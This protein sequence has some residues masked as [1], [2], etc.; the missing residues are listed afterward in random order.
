MLDKNDV[1]TID[2]IDD[3]LFYYGVYAGKGDTFIQACREDFYVASKELVGKNYY[4]TKLQCNR[5]TFL[6]L[7][8]DR[9]LYLCDNYPKIHER[10]FYGLPF[11]P[12][13]HIEDDTI[14]LSVPDKQI[15]IKYK[16]TR[17]YL[18]G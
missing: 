5:K 12:A 3:E 17:K 11:Y 13:E 14:E 8:K 15:Y 1:Q 7:T 9:S 2:L 10:K 6:F 4:A 16:F 18:G